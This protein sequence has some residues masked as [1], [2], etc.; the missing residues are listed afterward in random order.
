MM[1]LSQR[2]Q[3]VIQSAIK[4][5]EAERM[6]DLQ[7]ALETYDSEDEIKRLFGKNTFGCH[8]AVDR[9]FM[10]AENWEHYVQNHP[11]ILMDPEIYRM[12]KIVSSMMYEVYNSISTKDIDMPD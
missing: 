6:E 11:A 3:S 4:Y 5:A 8:E 1:E 10:V 2:E 12:S 9:S 7:K